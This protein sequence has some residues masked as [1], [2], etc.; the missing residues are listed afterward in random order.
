MLYNL[1]NLIFVG[2]GV[3]LWPLWN[4]VAEIAFSNYNVSAISYETYIL[5][6]YVFLVGTFF[7]NLTYTMLRFL[8]YPLEVT[9]RKSFHYSGFM[10]QT[11]T[12]DVRKVVNTI[13]IISVFLALF[14]TLSQLSLLFNS[15]Y[16]EAAYHVF[17]DGRQSV[18]SNYFYHVFVQ[19]IL[20][21]SYLI[22]LISNEGDRSMRMK[23][24]KFSGA[25]I[26]ATSL[27][28]MFKKGPL[29]LFF[30]QI[31]ILSTLKHF[32]ND[33]NKLVSGLVSKAPKFLIFA[34][35]LLSILYAFS[36]LKFDDPFE[37]FF[38]SITRIIGRLSI[39]A[40][41]YVEYFPNQH[42]F[43]GL[44]NV[45][46]F[47]KIFG[48]EAIP[49][50]ALVGTYFE[51][52]TLFDTS[53]VASS[54]LFDFYGINGLP[55]VFFGSLFIGVI[56]F[57]FDAVTQDLK[58]AKVRS[59]FI[60]LFSVIYYFTQASIF[61]SMAGYGGIFCVMLWFIVFKFRFKF[62]E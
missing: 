9:K 32:G 59:L 37:Y 21:A 31:F 50:S 42:D 39:P 61:R 10:T 46:L 33:R 24:Y 6:C 19:T 51:L 38:V 57:C 26:V 22:F 25:L 44:E 43:Y 35:A 41:F 54:A 36:G 58:S 56:I 17:Q 11:V 62:G 45:G 40:L 55:A 29:L 30:L 49:D 34:I 23:F 2:I 3:M 52:S 8:I 60:L 48:Y 13:L 7:I 5:A 14:H 1:M 16:F 4:D 12:D 27:L 15:N 18:A 47:A 20:P 28:L 53:T